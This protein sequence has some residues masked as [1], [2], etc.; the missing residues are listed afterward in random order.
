MHSYFSGDDRMYTITNL[1]CYDQIKC[2]SGFARSSLK[3]FSF[4]PKEEVSS[5]DFF[6]RSRCVFL[7]Q[8]GH[9]DFSLLTAAEQCYIQ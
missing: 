7:K 2:S 4:T 5:S 8:E 6:I 1:R 9:D 3:K